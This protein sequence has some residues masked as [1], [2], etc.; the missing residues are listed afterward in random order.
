LIEQ[1]NWK[2][3]RINDVGVHAQ[4]ALVLVNYGDAKGEE[5]FSLA[6]NIQSSVKEKFN[7]DITTEVNII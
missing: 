4:Q 3:R 6:M 7:I 2:G 1:C 5:I